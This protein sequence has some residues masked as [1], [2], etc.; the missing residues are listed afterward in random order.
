MAN[1]PGNG[2]SI[3]ARRDPGTGRSPRQTSPR[4]GGLKR[5]GFGARLL[6]AVSVAV[7]VAACVWVWQLEQRLDALE[8]ASGL[9][10]EDLEGRIADTDEGR[11]QSAAQS[12]QRISELAKKVDALADEV[13]KLW[14]SAWRRNQASI[15]ELEKQIEKLRGTIAD[16]ERLG[17]DVSR[18]N[19]AVARLQ[20]SVDGMR[21]ENAAERAALDAFRR[22]TNQK[23]LKIEDELAAAPAPAP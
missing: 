19:L 18:L 6:I 17:D 20:K 8:T 10:I 2:P 5:G 4:L 7:A 13:D 16:I 9:R 21:E 15:A 11:Q 14:A 12:D 22:T 1:D 23:L 3:T